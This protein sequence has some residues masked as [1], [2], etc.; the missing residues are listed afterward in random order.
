[1]Y[2]VIITD[3]LMGPRIMEWVREDAISGCIKPQPRAR[4]E[5]IL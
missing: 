5:G 4:T 3:R 2:P 1:M